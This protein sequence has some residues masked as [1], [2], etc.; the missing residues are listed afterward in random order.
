MG[1]VHRIRGLAR[2]AVRQARARSA[3][4]GPAP[5]HQAPGPQA[6]RQR[7]ARQPGGRAPQGP[8]PHVRK[9]QRDVAQMKERI[10]LLERE[11]QESRQLN[12]RVAEITDV[13]AEVLLPAE[14]R[15]ED[16]LRAVL[17]KYASSL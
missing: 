14:Q 13:V 8:G 3:R 15:D 4:P 16:R 10:A 9:L 7:A 2:R 1:T 11:L 17:E 12:K 5:G 6:P